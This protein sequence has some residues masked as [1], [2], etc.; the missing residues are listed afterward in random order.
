MYYI[1]CVC[2]CVYNGTAEYKA[3][4]KYVNYICVLKTY[5]YFLFFFL[6]PQTKAFGASSGTAEYKVAVKYVAIFLILSGT[7]VA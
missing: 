6:F 4:V 3:A 1:M 7:L 2:V 5:I